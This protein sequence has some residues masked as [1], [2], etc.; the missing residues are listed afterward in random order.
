MIFV[1]QNLPLQ[2]T[3]VVCNSCYRILRESLA[4]SLMFTRAEKTLESELEKQ[5][6]NFYLYTK[7]FII[8]RKI[9]T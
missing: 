7:W 3:D 4:F 1:F 5:N 6:G 9:F 8:F 2:E